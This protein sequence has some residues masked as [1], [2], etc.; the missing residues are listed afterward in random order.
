MKAPDVFGLIIRI[1]G[2]FVMT[3]GLWYLWAGV[4]SVMEIVLRRPGSTDG[5]STFDYFSFGLPAMAFGAV[6]FFCADWI[7]RLAYPPHRNQ[8]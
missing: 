5:S 3:Y 2:F 6:C 1:V 8:S 4:H 7:V